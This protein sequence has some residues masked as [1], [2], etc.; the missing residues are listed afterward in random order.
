M[1]DVTIATYMRQVQEW[2][3]IQWMQIAK[4]THCSFKMVRI[5][6]EGTVHEKWQQAIDETDTQYVVVVDD[7]CLVIADGWLEAILG[8][9]KS[10][11]DA[12]CITPIEI[13]D[14]ETFE[15]YFEDRNRLIPPNCPTLVESAWL[16]GY[17]MVIDKER[18][19]G[20]CVDVNIPHPKGA[21]DVDF[22]LTIRRAGFK[23]Y[24]TSKVCVYH[25]Y[26][27][28]VTEQDKLEAREQY[29]YLS[30]KWGKFYTESLN[31]Q[32]AGTIKL[33]DVVWRKQT[34]ED[35]QYL[36]DKYGI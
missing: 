15:V 16:P 5:C 7:D 2:H 28:P 25:P 13:K 8:E 23:C 11:P 36:A 9:L 1:I 27:N 34:L 4:H 32:A 18:T 17:M 14:R 20:A 19:P 30:H 31:Q 3:P 10:T 12:G 26:K 22:S 29:E 6:R 21:S 35:F 24:Y 33:P